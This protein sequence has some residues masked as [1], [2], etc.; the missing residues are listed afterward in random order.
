MKRGYTIE[1]LVD[2]PTSAAAAESA[3]DKENLMWQAGMHGDAKEDAEE[4]ANPYKGLV[5][6]P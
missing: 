6:P 1:S 3:I 5:N 2:D 4:P